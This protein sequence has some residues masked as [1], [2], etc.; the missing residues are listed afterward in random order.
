MIKKQKWILYRIILCSVFLILAYILPL[1]NVASFLLFLLTYFI[2]GFDVLWKSIRNIFHGQVFDENFLMSIATIGALLLGEY[3]EAV[4]VMLFYQVGELFQGIAVSKSRKSITELTEICAEVANLEKN[5]EIIEVDCEDLQVNDI[6]IIKAGEKIPVDGTVI[7]GN[8]NINTANITGESCPVFVSEND[9]ILSGCIN[10]DG[11]LKARVDKEFYDSTAYK[12]LDLVENANAAKT[13]TEKFITKFAKYYTPAVVLFA[14]CLAF[15][16]PIFV[17]NFSLWLHRALI[18]LVISCPCALVISVPLS[19]FGGIGCASKNGI[20]IKGSNFIETLSKCTIAVF[21][22]TGTLTKGCF[23]IFEISSAELSK[24]E[25]LRFAA[26]AEYYSDHPIAKSICK[27]YSGKIDIDSIKNVEEIAGKGMK[28]ELN[29]KIVFA[30]NIRLM[31]ELKIDV[32]IN[33]LASTV[34]YI[35]LDGEYKGHLAISD[36]IK[37]NGTEALE[38]IR[39]NGIDNIAM[40]TGD[41]KASGEL[42][43]KEL[44]LDAVYSELLPAD[45]VKKLEEIISGCK[46]SETVMYVGDGVNDAPVLARADV[47]IAMGALGTDAAIEAADVVL[48]DDNLEKIALALKISK[49]TMGIVKQNIVFAL[50]VK[51]AVMFLGALG[52]TNMWGAVFA[53]VGVSVIAILNAM[54]TLKIKY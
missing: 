17:G 16:P 11:V 37:E 29:N 2:V 46:S 44:K 22:K 39:K 6:I 20:L 49:K 31:E 38:Q 45:K 25:L 28:I 48:M 41:R 43:G 7:D 36:K 15:L 18:F 47:G 34:V 1:N 23:N 19:F 35:A 21:D 10:I 24:D 8:S 32:P 4:F 51:F 27:E 54:R 26:H 53:D 50:L 14:L 40:L 3:G 42:I 33:I 12:I 13:V 30:G 52:L 5:G 9:K